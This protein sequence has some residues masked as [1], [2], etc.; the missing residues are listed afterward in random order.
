MNRIEKEK[1]IV[2]AMIKLYCRKNH[3]IKNNITL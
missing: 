2:E 1:S 3:G